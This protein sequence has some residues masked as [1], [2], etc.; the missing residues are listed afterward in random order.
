[1]RGGNAPAGPYRFL[2]SFERVTT[3]PFH[4]IGGIL[5][6]LACLL[7]ALPSSLRADGPEELLA[8]SKAGA[9]GLA[10]RTVDRRQP[11][12]ARDPTTW[13]RWEQV[14]LSLL[15]E[16]ERWDALIERV[17]GYP[18]AL[19][20]A[21]LA[22]AGALRARAH[23]E[24]SEPGIARDLIRG[25]LWSAEYRPGP[26]PFAELRL[27]IVRSYLAEGLLDDARAALLRYRQDY[28]QESLT[29][30]IL[31]A[32]LLIRV[33]EPGLVGAALGEAPTREGRALALQAEL[34]RAKR[35]AAEIHAEA[36]KLAADEATRPAD[37]ARLWMVAARAASQSGRAIDRV[38]A[39]ERAIPWAPYLGDSDVIFAFDGDA[40][41]EAYRALGMDLGNQA[42]LLLG[43]DSAWLAA[44]DRAAEQKA[45]VKARS[46][47]A[48]V[49]L[50]G[51]SEPA[52]AAGH[53]RLASA[54]LAT[55]DG[56]AV[57]YGLY[58]DSPRF[59]RTE[60]IPLALRDVLANEALTRSELPL[61]SR[62]MA[63]LS[64]PPE[65]VDPF[66]WQLRRARVLI[67]GGEEDAGIDT[68]YAVL[69]GMKTLGRPQAD[70][71][72]QVVFDLQTVK[73]HEAAIN[74]FIVLQPRLEDAEQR[75][76]LLFWQADSYEAL[77][78][79]E[80]AAQLYLR[81]AMLFDPYA[82]DVWGQTS[83]F[84]A[85]EALAKAGLIADARN[86]YQDLLRVTKEQDR[87]V[88]LRQ[89]LQQLQLLQ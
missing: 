9:P 66:L 3:R 39:M 8:L 75:R 43:D 63:D 55:D 25:I 21:F 79:Y 20:P 13:A 33:G 56:N 87:R 12:L 73:R 10:L 1:L 40:L 4:S 60:S 78:E 65:G 44:A 26:E 86:V 27:M 59:E 29:E 15:L 53:A 7:P 71:F 48:V 70:R 81:S 6:L 61:A 38:L 5:A 31:H 18:A 22:W 49:A 34:D 68:L 80:R 77:G 11:E 41:W 76:E 58:L 19:D 36:A 67:L 16:A 84:H 52:R 85:A 24:S 54:L 42:Q 2:A 69:A 45:V 35:D 62:L 30:R 28:T 74:L 23:L 37:R 14:R 64:E 83:R 88:V 46:L 57:V 89:R 50:D 47:N 82:Y 51:V 72:L 17:G 32:R